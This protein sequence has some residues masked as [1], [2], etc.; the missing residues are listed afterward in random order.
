MYQEKA[1]LT[2]F[3][4]YCE[5]TL[6]INNKLN[7]MYVKVQSESFGRLNSVVFPDGDKQEASYGVKEGLFYS[8]ASLQVHV[9]Y[10]RYHRSFHN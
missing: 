4:Y 2:L 9:T 6:Y 7:V 5:K 3:Q 10:T 8:L 1:H